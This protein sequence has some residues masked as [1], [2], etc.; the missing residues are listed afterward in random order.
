M[1]DKIQIGLLVVIAGALI[2]LAVSRT[3]SNA[4]V[5]NTTATTKAATT[6]TPTRTLATNAA[7]PNSPM[8][9]PGA[10][11]QQAEIDNRPKTTVSFGSTTD[12]EHDFGHVK[13]GSENHYTFK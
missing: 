7:S 2:Y 8:A 1:K 9:D 6:T 11:A 10:V 3:G 13:A 5:A 12:Y 4:T